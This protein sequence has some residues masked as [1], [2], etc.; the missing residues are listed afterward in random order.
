MAWDF[1]TGPEFQKHLDWATQLVREEVRC[2]HYP[3]ARYT[4][5]TT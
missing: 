2:S 3:Q 4:A 1:Q 5:S